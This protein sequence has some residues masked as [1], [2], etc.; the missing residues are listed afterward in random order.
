[1]K[2]KGIVSMQLQEELALTYIE[3]PDFCPC[4]VKLKIK[5]VTLK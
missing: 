2:Y 4:T 1:M 5:E 3:Y